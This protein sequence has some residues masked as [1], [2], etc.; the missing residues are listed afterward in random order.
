M[1]MSEDKTQAVENKDEVI[2][3]DTVSTIVLFN[4]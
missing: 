1:F 3:R 4:L 2:R